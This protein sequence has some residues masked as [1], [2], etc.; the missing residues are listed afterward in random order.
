MAEQTATTTVEPD[1]WDSHWDAYSPM[2][3]KNPAQAYRRRLALRLLSAGGTPAR[4]LDIGS[5]Q[6]DFLQS[7]RRKW[8]RTELAGLEPSGSGIEETRQKVPGARLLQRDLLRDEPPPPELAGWATHAVCSEVLEHVDDDVRLM[9]NARAFLSPRAL[10]IVT[11]P[12]GRM[13]AFDRHIGH[14]RHYTPEA[15]AATLRAAGYEVEWAARAGFPF[16]NLYRQ[17]VI[18]RGTSLVQDVATTDGGQPGLPARLAMAVFH[19]LLR[20]TLTRSPWGT[21]IVAAARAGAAVADR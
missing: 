3:A 9:A 8:P 15:L 12:G 21:Q 17:V 11:V 13:S 1:D 2:A 7:A 14:R 16:L 4:V 10:T 19:P 18:A 5:G 20:A 6:G